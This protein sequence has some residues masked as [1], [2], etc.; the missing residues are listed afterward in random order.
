[1]Q[2]HPTSGKKSNE[3]LRFLPALPSATLEKKM[4]ASLDTL[5]LNPFSSERWQPI[6]QMMSKLCFLWNGQLRQINTVQHRI[7]IQ[8]EVSP[9][10]H[11]SYRARPVARA[12]IQKKMDDMLQQE[13][14]EP[15]QSEWSSS[16]ELVLKPD[17]YWLCSIDFYR[18]A[19]LNAITIW[20]TYRIPWMNDCMNF[21]GEATFCSAIDTLLENWKVPIAENDQGRISFT[22]QLRKRSGTAVLCTVV[23]VSVRLT[24]TIGTGR[25]SSICKPTLYPVFFQ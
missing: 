12:A 4:S 8:P 13:V 15:V 16:V 22:C 9:R 25:V 23:C 7:K 1:M 20:G 5:E 2:E 6:R 17:D 11:R 3:A 10:I 24:L 14:I 19:G 21:L 18:P